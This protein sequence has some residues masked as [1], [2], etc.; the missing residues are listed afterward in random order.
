MYILQWLPS[1]RKMPSIWKV[2]F[3]LQ[4]KKPNCFEVC[5]PRNRKKV[6]KI[7]QTK[8]D[9]EVSS[10]FDFFVETISI[11]DPLNVNEVKNESSVW[12]ITLTSNGPSISQFRIK[13]ILAHNET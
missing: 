12:S 11:Q 10:N 3:K 6:H 7:D 5:C 13:L 2:V 1:Q 4:P 8:R 9:C